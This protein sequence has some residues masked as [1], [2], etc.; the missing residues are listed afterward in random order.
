M[1]KF[2]YKARSKDGSPEEGYLEAKDEKALVKEL[3]AKGIFPIIIKEVG[4]DKVVS[5]AKS[6]DAL[7][8]KRSKIKRRHIIEFTSQLSTLLSA[9]VGL[10]SALG[11]VANQ[12]ESDEFR[13]VCNDLKDRVNKG[14]SFSFA[15]AQYKD[16]FS[17]FYIALVSAGEKGAFLDSAL[18]RLA[19]IL[20]YEDEVRNSVIGELVYPAL[21]VLIGFASVLFILL[22]VIPKMK[23]VLLDMGQ[24]LPVMT[25]F[26][27][28]ASASLIEY[29]WFWGLLTGLAILFIGMKLSQQEDS[30]T[31]RLDG[32]LLKIPALGK[33]IVKIET[34]RFIKVFGVLLASGINVVESL[35]ISANLVTNSVIKRHVL[36]LAEKIRHGVPL[37]KA[38]EE[39]KVFP[40]ML[41]GAI[42]TGQE[43]GSLDMVLLKLGEFY[44]KEVRRQIK[45]VVAMLGPVSI[46][47]VG[48]FI[49]LI[50]ISVLMPIFQMNIG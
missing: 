32:F 20:E 2:F 22:F 48:V 21:V 19:Q 33:M 40:V 14:Q 37:S 31:K 10:V 34:G 39:E 8:K 3:A 49:G 23:D 12:V 25:R 38:V 45:M 9:G 24:A 6:D 17:P 29:W 11:M 15:L 28:W 7:L 13:I 42:S 26:L 5:P 18:I 1:P 16:I 36:N 44:E 47:T 50:V 27:L 30:D 43:S 41:S 46:L 4:P 35:E